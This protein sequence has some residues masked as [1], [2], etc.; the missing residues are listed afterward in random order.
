MG[1][2]VHLAE[3][4][5]G[6]EVPPVDQMVALARLASAAAA[7]VA[8]ASAALAAAAAALASAL[9]AL[10]AQE[11]LVVA[12]LAANQVALVLAVHAWDHVVA[13]HGGAW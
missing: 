8:A 13:G 2:V 4:L 5:V 11:A 10:E 6:L 1:Q 3:A 7:A 9:A 12:D